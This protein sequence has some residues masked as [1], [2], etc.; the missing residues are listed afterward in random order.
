MNVTWVHRVVTPI[1]SFPA[2]TVLI[3]NV[4]EASIRVDSSLWMKLTCSCGAVCHKDVVL[5]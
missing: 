5:L 1:K 3:I 2:G 4:E